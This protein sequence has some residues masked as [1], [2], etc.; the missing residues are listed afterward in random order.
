MP[1]LKPMKH[2]P[3]QG[4]VGRPSKWDETLDEFLASGAQFSEVIATE[5]DPQGPKGHLSIYNSLNAARKRKGYG[6]KV[7]VKLRNRRVILKRLAK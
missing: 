7:E 1:K 6:S 4:K 2:L 5:D 3:D